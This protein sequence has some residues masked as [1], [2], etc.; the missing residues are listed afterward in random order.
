MKSFHII[1]N[2]PSPYR[3]HLFNEMWRQL[4][5][6]GIEFHVH[7][8]SDMSRGHD[9]RPLSWRNPKIDFPHTYWKDYGIKHHHYNPGMLC[10][11]RKVK[12]DYL[13]IGST[14]DTFTGFFASQ[15]FKSSIKCAWS[16]G[17]TKTTGKMGGIL[18]W[19]K[20]QAFSGCKFIGVP[21]SD[22]AKYVALHQSLTKKKMPTPVYLPNL[23]D[24]KRFKPRAQFSSEIIVTVRRQLNADDKKLCIIPARLEWYKGLKEFLTAAST[25]SSIHDWRIVIMG[26]GSLNEEIQTLIEEL[27]LDQIV[28]ILNFV[29]Y[30]EMPAFYAASDLFLL[31]SLMDRNPLTVVEAV[32]SGLP[33][34]LSCM[35]GNVEEGVTE[36][37]NGWV[38]PV[39]DEAQYGEKLKAVFSTDVETLHEMGQHSLK[40]NAQFWD[41][42]LAVRNFLKGLG[43]EGL[44]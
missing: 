6:V 30:A 18:G 11:L 1:Q 14:F 17:N 40:E 20:R 39:K 42:K 16:E 15:G 13:I 23:I 24:E 41:T 27:K 3:L 19:I 5:E 28:S 2:I 9:E 32:H 44:K 37:K 22:A 10:Y 12:P 8:M 31:P 21:G 34:A 25:I 7:F 38:L 26:Q 29:P 43:V 33:I 35:A 36:G 4:H